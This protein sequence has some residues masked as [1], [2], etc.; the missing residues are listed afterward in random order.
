MIETN[1]LGKANTQSETLYTYNPWLVTKSK[2][3]Q[4]TASGN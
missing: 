2:F 3:E 1:K 4:Q